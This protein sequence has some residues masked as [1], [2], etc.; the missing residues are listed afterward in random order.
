MGLGSA[1]CRAAPMDLML[2]FEPTA[3]RDALLSKG[4][5]QIIAAFTQLPQTRHPRDE[6]KMVVDAWIAPLTMTEVGPTGQP[7]ENVVSV[8]FLTIHGEL[9]ECE[10]WYGDVTR[11]LSSI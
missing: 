6:S 4:P 11:E 1:A 10:A 5:T 7:V 2:P 3:K 8:V 9:I